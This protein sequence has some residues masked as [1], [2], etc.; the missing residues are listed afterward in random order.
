[1]QIDEKDNIQGEMQERTSGDLRVG[2]QERTVD[3]S[4]SGNMPDSISAFKDGDTDLDVFCK[5]A[6]VESIPSESG[7][8]TDRSLETR[9]AELII[10]V[11]DN[12]GN[13]TRV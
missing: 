13:D 3:V 10:P 5:T 6:G 2:A 8:D 11:S 12:G 7:N 9:T 1:M 4:G